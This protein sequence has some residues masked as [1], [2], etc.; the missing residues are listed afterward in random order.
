MRAMSAPLP[1]RRDRFLLLVASI[2]SSH[3]SAQP[4][5]NRPPD[6]VKVAPVE[7]AE[8]PAGSAFQPEVSAPEEALAVIHVPPGE[9]PA[10]IDVPPEGDSPESSCD[11]SVGVVDCSGI[12]P[13]CEGLEGSCEL[14]GRGYGYKPRVAAAIARCWERIGRRACNM[15]A[16][17]Q[18]NREGT[19]A[20]CPDLRFEAE[21]SANLQRCNAAHARPDYTI[22]ECVNVLSSLDDANRTW[23]SGAMGPTREGCKLVFPVY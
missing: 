13:T 14:L 5:A 7:T 15:R 3:C 20:A 12:A 19:Q 6:Y 11:N 22:E 9:A 16:R 4:A 18:C 23:A 10:V 2:A 8:A 17:A 21:C 1:I